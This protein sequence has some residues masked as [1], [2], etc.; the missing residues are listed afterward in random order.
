MKDTEDLYDE[1]VEAASCRGPRAL[2]RI[3]TT[4]QPAGGTGT[5]VY[6]PS[7]PDPVRTNPNRYL[8]EPRFHAGS[9][10]SAVVLDQIPAQAN[11]CEDALLQGQRA[12]AFQIPL[13]ELRHDG[14]SESVLTSL[15]F[16]HRYADAYLRDS[17]LDG[18]SFDRSP[19]GRSVI[20]SSRD[21]ASALYKHDPGSLVYGAWNSH[22]K[23]RQAKF[24]RTYASEILGWDPVPGVRAAGRM[25]PYNLTGAAKPGKNGGPW[26]YGPVPTKAKGEKLSEIG[27]GNIAPQDSHGGMTVS[28]AERIATISLAGLDRIGFGPVSAEAAVAARASL[29]AY[30]LLADRLAFGRPSVWLRSGCE[31]VTVTESIEWVLRG[32]EVEPFDLRLDQALE[33]FQ[34]SVAEAGKL[35]LPMSTETV[36]LTPAANLAKAI[37]FALLKATDGQD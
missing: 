18:V 12:G 4:Y 16:P 20:G 21:D 11:R 19:L 2:L 22:R 32:D 31:L 29:A 27:H 28:G 8:V 5:K 13:L 33:L 1:L 26:T 34:R 3:R 30:A 37:D 23:G 7:F 6:P 15:E 24:A 17:E 9:E 14:E 36:Q 35:G 10:R 25:D